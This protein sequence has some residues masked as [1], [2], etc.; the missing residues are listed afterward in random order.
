MAAPGEQQTEAG[1]IEPASSKN[2]GA[3]ALQDSHDQIDYETISHK[4]SKKKVKYW[5]GLPSELKVIKQQGNAKNAK[6]AHKMA[7]ERP[8]YS[9]LQMYCVDRLWYKESKFDEHADNPTSAAYGIPQANPGRKMAKAGRN[10]H[11]R[12]SVQIRWGYKH[13]IEKRYKKPCTAWW[14]FRLNNWY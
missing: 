5:Y 10:W 4:T 2:V 11:S 6:L 13:Y 3:L 9:R 12:P 14:H 8:W 7:K 1:P